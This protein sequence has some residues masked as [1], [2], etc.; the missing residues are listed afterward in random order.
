MPL[1]LS[2]GLG[3]SARSGGGYSAE[4]G[5]GAK[6][7]IDYQGVKS[8]GAPYYWY[9]GTRYTSPANIPGW[10][11]SRASTGYAEKADGTLIPFAANTPRITDKGLLVEGVTT[12]LLLRS[13]EFATA[14]WASGG[15]AGTTIVSDAVTAPDGTLTADKIVATVTSGNHNRGQQY[16]SASNVAYTYSVFVKAAE[17]PRVLIGMTD[18]VTGDASVTINL[19][20]G[21]VVAGPNASGSWTSPSVTVTAFGGGWYRVALTATRGASGTI[22]APYLVLDNGSTTSFAGDGT[23]G[24]YVWGAQ[25][26]T[27]TFADSYIP[28]TTA[29]ATRAADNASITGLGA[30]LGQ[31]RTN[32][33]LQ[34]QALGTSPWAAAGTSTV[35][36]NAGVAPDG[37]TTATLISPTS[38]FG[39]R[40]QTLNVAGSTTYTAAISEKWVSGNTALNF[41]VFDVTNSTVLNSQTINVTSSWQ[42]F[43]ATF[44]TA[45]NT[46]QVYILV[47]DTNASGFGSFLAWG[48]HVNRGS[49]AEDYIPTTTA[50]VT[51][52]NPFTMQVWDGGSAGG[53]FPQRIAATG[54]AGA[55]VAG[56]FLNGPT[57]NTFLASTGSSDR[58]LGGT[59][60]G[61]RKSA[62]RIRTNEARGAVNNTLSASFANSGPTALERVYLGVKS[63]GGQHLNGYLQRVAIFGDLTDAQLQAVTA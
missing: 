16:S 29:A 58:N 61:D 45:A 38:S 37:T 46:T 48:A 32:L 18:T 23:S 28:T 4:I 26:Q 47:R 60:G 27:G 59:G 8:G 43:S 30:I 57:G 21:A 24:T 11:F 9:N 17:Y 22:I 39:G 15:T 42:R 2:L 10:S 49:V 50:A 62:A 5:M 1:S 36:D 31:F 33:L 7:I 41:T 55:P 13:Q 6:L 52:G 54:S 34:S 3:L 56:M 25:L 12:N 53:L 20:T 44:T 19:S 35:S 40:V 63:D 51:V 14:P